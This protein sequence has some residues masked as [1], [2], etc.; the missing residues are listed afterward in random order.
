MN[1]LGTQNGD[2]NS[3]SAALPYSILDPLFS[4]LTLYIFSSV[5]FLLDE[6]LGGRI[7]GRG[8]GQ[9]PQQPLGFFLTQDCGLRTGK[10][11]KIEL[12]NIYIFVAN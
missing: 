2:G 9:A 7:R 6:Q 11:K 12:D 5:L 3:N 10:G 4:H 1:F 8:G